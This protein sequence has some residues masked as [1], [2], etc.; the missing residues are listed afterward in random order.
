MIKIIYDET[1]SVEL[2]Y[3]V[4]KPGC[5]S[6]LGPFEAF[7]G[8]KKFYLGNSYSAFEEALSVIQK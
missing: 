3:L 2:W 4:F 8:W 5:K 7:P 6:Y 1:R